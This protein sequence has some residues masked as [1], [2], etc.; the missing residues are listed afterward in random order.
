[1]LC[2]MYVCTIIDDG[3]KLSQWRYS[4]LTIP[5]KN[6]KSKQ[7][8]EDRINRTPK[9]IVIR[10]I[11]EFSSSKIYEEAQ[12]EWELIG[13][14]DSS[15]GDFTDH[16]ELCNT[17]LFKENWEIR[18]M[19]T[20]ISLKVG[21]DCIRR[22]VVL[23]GT[24]SAEGTNQYM[25]NREQEWSSIKELRLTYKNVIMNPLP[26]A[27]E[28]NRFHK[29]LTHVLEKRGLFPL[30]NDLKIADLNPIFKDIFGFDHLPP[31]KE[32][33]KVYQ[34]LYDPSKIA[35]IKENKKLHNPTFKEGDTF[36]KKRGATYVSLSKSSVYRNPA[37]KY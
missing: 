18:N 16:C 1:M 15:S 7:T 36:K 32:R 23:S 3:A 19:I 4:Y 14:I 27:R 37:D 12:T 34:I 5:F 10:S 29:K 22:C 2:G 13:V 26:T 17:M 6:S 25:D 31:I 35:K 21:S 20:G 8:Q 24:G 30:R 28:L 11:V 9:R 33:W